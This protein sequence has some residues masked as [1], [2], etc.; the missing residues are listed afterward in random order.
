MNKEKKFFLTF[1][2]IFTALF[3]F[4]C[5]SII[6]VFVFNFVN[7]SEN[8]LSVAYLF[9]Q[10]II[11]ALF[12][13]W[14]LKAYLTKSRIL[15]VMCLYDNGTIN[16][17]VVTKGIVF[18]SIFFLASIYFGLSWIGLNLGLDFF[19]TG[20]KSALTNFSLMITAVAMSFVLYPYLTKEKTE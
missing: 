13:Y 9:L 10:M 2:L 11:L 8:L 14:S 4:D 15:S 16:K 17:S 20:L 6:N 3:I 1:T 19:V 18:A 12:F 5:F 7:S